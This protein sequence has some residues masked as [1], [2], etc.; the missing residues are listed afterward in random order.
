MFHESYHILPVFE[1]E[2]IVKATALESGEALQIADEVSVL[3]VLDHAPGDAQDREQLAKIM[4]A[5]GLTEKSYLIVATDSPWLRYR[6][7]DQLKTVLLFG[8]KEA[9]WGINIVLPYHKTIKFDN[10]TW[11]KTVSI[12]ELAGNQQT[13]AELWNNALKPHFK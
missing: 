13:K 2:R 4:Q 5:C 11:I 6:H 10:R 7:L 3:V 12:R 9:D 8:I 1:R